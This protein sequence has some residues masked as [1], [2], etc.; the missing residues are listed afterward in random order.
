LGALSALKTYE[1][2][3]VAIDSDSDGMRMD[4]LE[5]AFAV[6]GDK[7][8]LVYVNTDFQN[9]TGRS[10]SEERRKAFIKLIENYDVAVLE[11]AAY[12]ELSYSDERMRPLISYDRKGQ[13]IYIGT[14]SKTF[15]PGLRTGWIC[16]SREVINRF[17][18][19]KTNVDLS[20]A[21]ILQRQVAYYLKNR[22]LDAHIKG[23]CEL[24]KGRRD[25]MYEAI[26]REFPEDSEYSLPGGGLF[27]WVKLPDY[28][29]TRILLLRAVAEKVA[30]MPGGAFY[31]DSRRNSEMR[32]N[33][34]NMSCGDIEKGI[35]VLGRLI[36]EYGETDG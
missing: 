35:G 23:I 15:C 32:L 18:I 16:G 33:F 2:S 36:R 10:W 17:L 34:S 22:D 28:I 24:Y 11:D 26:R 30:F 14:F 3:L 19:L 7:V 29:D 13:F 25:V 4:E 31:P 8:K 9:P 6:H 20:P 12:A 5:K 21:T 27:F 1:A